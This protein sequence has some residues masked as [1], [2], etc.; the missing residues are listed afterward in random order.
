[1]A[2]TLHVSKIGFFY[3]C[4][5]P[6]PDCC[7]LTSTPIFIL[8]LYHKIAGSNIVEYSVSGNRTTLSFMFCPQNC[9]HRVVCPHN[10]SHRAF[11]WIACINL[12]QMMLLKRIILISC[13]WRCTWQA[14]DLY[15][16]WLHKSVATSGDSFCP[17]EAASFWL[18]G[19]VSRSPSENRE[20]WASIV[21]AV[22]SVHLPR[23]SPGSC[24]CY[25]GI[26]NVNSIMNL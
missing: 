22:C 26:W 21:G 3:V 13:P 25:N 1:M 18:S 7:S 15:R 9:Q 10:H 24:S 2:Q 6:T 16:H 4:Y 19:G 5:G 12:R 11:L 23:R 14:T 17:Y 20:A 8:T